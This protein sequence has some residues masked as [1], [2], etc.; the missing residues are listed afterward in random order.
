M[1]GWSLCE[2]LGKPPDFAARW[3]LSKLPT[4]EVKKGLS[5]HGQTAQS[6]GAKAQSRPF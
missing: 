3:H 1:I 4:T 5:R 6:G 2:D